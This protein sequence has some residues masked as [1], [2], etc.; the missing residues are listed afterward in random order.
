MMG[1]Q[2][3]GLTSRHNSPQG[4]SRTDPAGAASGAGWRPPAPNRR[5][6]SFER[7]CLAAAVCLVAL[8]VG[9]WH[10]VQ[11]PFSVR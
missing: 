4:S 11:Q 10:R 6:M 9:R 1:L 3:Q 7:W 5:R 2:Q 8:H